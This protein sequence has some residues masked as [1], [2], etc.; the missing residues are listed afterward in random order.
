ML[1]VRPKSEKSFEK[2]YSEHK[3]FVLR[4]A[5]YVSENEEMAEDIMQT[6]F[7]QLYIHYE[8]L[9]L[10]DIK[11][12]LATTARNLALNV[13]KGRSKE[14]LEEDIILIS[15]MYH[16]TGALEDDYWEEER[17]KEILYLEK[18]MFAALYKKNKKWYQAVTMVYCLHYPQKEVADELG[19]SLESL[20]SM[21]YRAR[22][23]LTKYCEKFRKEK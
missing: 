12:W 16:S 21:L 6:T 8:H 15:D 7:M 18:N 17:R 4:T 5:A 14:T 23:W 19:M 20:H 2:L 11:R 10:K 1:K 9:D 22:K 3:N 13:I